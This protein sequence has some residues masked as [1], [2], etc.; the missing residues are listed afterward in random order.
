MVPVKEKHRSLK[1]FVFVRGTRNRIRRRVELSGRVVN[2]QEF[3]QIDRT[4]FRAGVKAQSCNFV[5]D[6]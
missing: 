2:S 1:V 3:R 6:S 4:S 5:L